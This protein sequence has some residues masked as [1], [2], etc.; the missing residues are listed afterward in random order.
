MTLPAYTPPAW[1]QAGEPS[2][3]TIA[4]LICTSPSAH[5]FLNSSFVNVDWLRAREAAPP[6]H[7]PGGRRACDIADAATVRAWNE[8]WGGSSRRR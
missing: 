3:D 5:S 1:Q 2:I 4:P 6:A 7:P 8:L